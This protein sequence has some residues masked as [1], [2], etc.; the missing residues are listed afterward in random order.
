MKR[1]LLWIGVGLGAAAIVVL[2]VLLLTTCVFQNHRFSPATCTEP[3]T[4]ARCGKTRGEPLGHAYAS[5]TCT[6]P[7]T[8]TRCGETRGEPLG[9]EYL[10]A[11]CTEPETCL[12]CGVTA[13]EPL[14]HLMTEATYQSPPTCLRCG[15][16]EGEPKEAA[17]ADAA[18]NEM[19]VG[20]PC[21]YTTA[22]YEDHDIDV[23]GTVEI[24]DYEVIEGSE[25]FP[26]REGYEWHV[27]TVRLVFSGED[28]QQN[29]MQSALTYGDFYTL[30]SEIGTTVDENGLRPF[31]VNWYGSRVQCWQKS[32]P[33]E[34]AD[35]F[36]HE[37]RFTWQEGVL[38][39]CG[40]DG[41]LLIFYHYRLAQNADRLFL[42]AADVLDEN[43]LVFRMK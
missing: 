21:P 6:E 16:T 37:L 13:G 39:P 32:G 36:E 8:C 12:R 43:A 23:T 25:I 3:E 14:G 10:P 26:P 20:K 30:D 4:C 11:T 29:G 33:D 34:E 28:A 18:L 35:W 40:Y 2:S 22:S 7:E 19:E 38:V 17:L 1:T 42:P 27:A 24:T 31:V 41:T 15:F 9:H 5:A